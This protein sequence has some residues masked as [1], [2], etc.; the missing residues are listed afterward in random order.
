MS[1]RTQK[2]T[3]VPWYFN[4][5]TALLSKNLFTFDSYRI[6]FSERRLVLISVD[7]ILVV[8]ATWIA[9]IAWQRLYLAEVAN[10]TA[11]QIGS[12]D[13]VGWHWYIALLACW[14]ALAWLN[15]LY[16]IPS[17]YHAGQNLVRISIVAT[18]A[19]LLYLVIYFITPVDALPRIFFVSFLLLSALFISL[20]RIGYVKLSSVLPFRHRV[21][22]VG[23][24]R[25]AHTI[26]AALDRAPG[27]NY[28]I[29]GFVEDDSD[30][31]IQT[32]GA[33]EGGY[34]LRPAYPAMSAE[35]LL[36]DV[37]VLAVAEQS[38]RDGKEL[39]I[40][41]DIHALPSLIKR[42][43]VHEIV[44]ATNQQVDNGLFDKLVDCQA[45]GVYVSWMPKLYEQI[46]RR[47]PIQHI[48]PSWALQITSG[49][50]IF[51]RIQQS[52]KRISDILLTLLALPSILILV[53]IIGLAI[54]L[55]DNGPIFYKQVRCGRGG[56]PFNI[57]KFRTM[58]VNAE[59]DGEAQWARADDNRVTRI[60]RILRRARLDELP[61][62]FNILR[63][64]MS[65]V[66]PRP[67]RPEFVQNLQD[68]IPYYRARLMVKPG[69]TGW[70]QVHY[71]YGSSNED[72]EVKLQYDLYYIR[73]WSIWLDFYTIFQTFSV[74]F[75][76]EGV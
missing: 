54:W 37:D 49:Q 1:Y 24:G 64:Q 34:P 66:G 71:R 7:G 32:L 11:A 62:V 59:K 50:P 45:Q 57:Y 21:L 63:G 10:Q 29:V 55:D 67:E 2:P 30:L 20:W 52:I 41:G 9:S 6:P 17:S 42:H 28:E 36:T 60:G 53:P 72:A 16:D 65:I 27:L 5:I 61:Q 31:S 35:D 73:N 70:A 51:G 23:L 76:L 58:S 74:V 48:D 44:I 12:V 25:R 13:L 40:V 43:N 38:E 47:I 33:A 14:W 26:A 8:L 22:V 19:L 46:F 68:E 56:K 18:L 4:R 3:T 15:D 39:K 69:L 75:R